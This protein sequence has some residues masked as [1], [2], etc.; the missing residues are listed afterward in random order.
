L[1]TLKTE[2]IFR[3]GSEALE[4]FIAPLDDGMTRFLTRYET[5]KEA[6]N[7]SVRNR[8]ATSRRQVTDFK[9]PQ[10]QIR[11]ILRQYVTYERSDRVKPTATLYL[12]PGYRQGDR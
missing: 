2:R 8:E 11:N 9:D 5:Q 10:P 4:T 6:P 7:Y 3:S 12:P 1:K